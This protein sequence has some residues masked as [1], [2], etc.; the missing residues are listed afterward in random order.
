MTLDI[1]DE[2]SRG[3]MLIGI[4]YIHALIA[5]AST[6]ADPAG[7]T[8]SFV[9]IK[10][11]A[12]HV[13][14][15]FFLSGMGARNLGKRSFP[16]VVTQSL[17]LLLLASVSHAV[18]YWI[19]PFIQNPPQYWGGAVYG[20]AKPLVYAT[21]YCTFIGWFFVVLAF[22]R[23][24]A[25]AFE[26]S[27]VWFAG[28]VALFGLLVLASQTL[29]VPDNLYEWRNV[30][31]A[32]LFFLIGMR[33]PKSW[34]VPDAL[35]AAALVTTL[36]LAWFNRPG[37]LSAGPCLDCDIMFVSQP[38]VG[39]FGS[40]PVFVVQEVAFL[41]FILWAGQ[42]G[43]RLGLSRLPRYFG[44]HSVQLLLLHGWVMAALFPFVTPLLPQRESIWL[45]VAILILNPL[46]HAGLLRLLLP[47]IDRVLIFCMGAARWV[48]SLIDR[49]LRLRRRKH[50]I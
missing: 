12:P 34:R 6:R 48:M 30:P 4:L 5:F 20:F 1:R 27:W 18:G 45:M 22:A 47:L 50:P 21:G 40:L 24:L 37:L 41:I 29:R 23:M 11:L 46:L 8:A 39:Q 33:I 15:F 17:M 25:Y 28:G 49:V 38:M 35:G 43:L 14:V 9:Q 36:T 10:L 32:T 3:Y 42:L 19:G 13:S 7:A 44:R 31:A 16:S 2:T 26:R